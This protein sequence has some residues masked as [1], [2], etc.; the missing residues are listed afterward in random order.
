MVGMRMPSH[1][2]AR[3]TVVPGSTLTR[4]PSIVRV[5]ITASTSACSKSGSW[6]TRADLEVRP[7]LFVSYDLDGIVL[8]DLTAHV[9]AGAEV[10]IHF[11]LL[12][13][14]IRDRSHGAGLRAQGTTD[15][16]VRHAIADQGRAA[17]GRTTL[18]V[19][20]GFV[21]LAKIAERGGNRVGRGLTQTAEAPTADVVGEGLQL[22]EVVAA[23][24]SF[25]EPIQNLEHALGADT[26][27]GT[28]AAGF[29]LRE[30]QEEARDIDHAVAVVEYHQPARSHNCA[31]LSQRIVIDGCVGEARRDAAAG[32]TAQLHRFELPAVGDAASDLLH[33]F[34]N[35]DAHGDFDQAA[36]IDLSGQCKDLR[37]PAGWGA[38]GG[39]GFG[40]VAD[41]PR[42]TGERFDVVDD[43]R[44]AAEALFDR[45]GRPQP[46]HPALAFERLDQRGLLAA[47]ECAGAFAHFQVQRIEV[48]AG[49]RLDDC[50]AHMAHRQRVFG[51]D[52]QVA[53]GGS[54]G[55]RRNGKAFQNAMR[56]GLEHGAVHECAGVAFVA[57]ADDVF[58]GVRLRATERPFAGGRETRSAAPAQ[59]GIGDG[60]DYLFG[61]QLLT[62]AF[63]GAVAVARQ[64]V[65]DVERIDFAAVLQHDPFLFCGLWGR[66]VSCG[67]LVIGPEVPPDK[68][69]R[70][71]NGNVAIEGDAPAG[72]HHLHQRL[73]IAHPIAADRF[74][75]RSLLQ[76][77]SYR[78][79]A[80]GDASVAK[81]DP[82]FDRAALHAVSVSSRWA[83]SA[84]ALDGVS[85][86]AVCPSTIST[87]ARLQQPRQATS[88]MVNMRAASV[89]APSGMAR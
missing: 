41:N 10:L 69:A 18:L 39:E 5:T 30:F 13:R 22:F 68:K 60:G 50:G 62:A 20:V 19:Q 4:R 83:S 12:V 49:A 48:S 7:T 58:D 65:V 61:G 23:A 25:A 75:L 81:S 55:V 59:A 84:L 63:E 40:A 14:T 56:V 43:G 21:L 42:H 71:L 66:M 52:I 89:S 78:F 51:A 86:P 35:G 32:R 45:V 37:S 80:A 11:V 36:A 73:A 57:V 16:V 87:G 47:D 44:L 6:R 2:A 74:D 64:V 85:L 46:R 82:D 3:S 8:A 38:A 28:L 72:L 24:V 15:A 17:A 76:D 79:R 53:L 26:A 70:G 54:D 33:D 88:P 31:S 67:R 1:C 77:V 34:A 9:T 29:R 27:E